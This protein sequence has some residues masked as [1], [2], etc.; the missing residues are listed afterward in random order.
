MVV[1]LFT[2]KKPLT[3]GTESRIIVR[4]IVE[5]INNKQRHHGE[6]NRERHVSGWTESVR[7]VTDLDRVPVMEKTVLF[8]E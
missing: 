1:H 5:S 6:H 4:A 3:G 2:R 8:S 7:S